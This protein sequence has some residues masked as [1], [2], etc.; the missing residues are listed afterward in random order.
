MSRCVCVHEPPRAAG[1]QRSPEE[2]Q[3]GPAAEA[4]GA[5]G[6]AGG[7]PGPRLR[8][9]RMLG[10]PE[11]RLQGQEAGTWGPVDQLQ[12]QG[13]GVAF[14]AEWKGLK[15]IRRVLQ[16]EGMRVDICSEEF[17]CRGEQRSPAE[18]RGGCEVKEVF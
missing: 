3:Q 5:V 11:D 9:R 1:G 7:Q 2:G 17:S 13:A 6:Q 4:G 16:G 18:L 14:L 8:G 10:G 15:P 12:G